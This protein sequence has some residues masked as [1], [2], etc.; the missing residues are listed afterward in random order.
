MNAHQIKEEINLERLEVD[1]ATET[2]AKEHLKNLRSRRDSNKTNELLTR[3]KKTTHS[4]ENLLPLFIECVDNNITLGEIC[5][6]LRQE[7]GEY[8]PSG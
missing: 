7:W 4:S 5:K 3:L 8:S 2:T 6:V 1:P